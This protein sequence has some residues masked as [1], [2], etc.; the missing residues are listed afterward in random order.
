MEIKSANSLVNKSL[1]SIQKE[2]GIKTKISFHTA[3]HSFANYCVK[4][5]I[6]IKTVQ[7][8]LG[9]SKISTTQGYLRSFDQ[10]ESDN[11]LDELFS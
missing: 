9:H 6:H 5:K 3:R 8:L 11:A 4:K 1:I 2:L 7:E 10:E